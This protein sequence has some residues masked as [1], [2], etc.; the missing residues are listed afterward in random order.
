MSIPLGH[1]ATSALRM[2]LSAEGF[3]GLINP[4][5][6]VLLMV[7]NALS[8]SILDPSRLHLL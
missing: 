7:C 4:D 8:N 3:L 5:I 6:L 2:E 1:K